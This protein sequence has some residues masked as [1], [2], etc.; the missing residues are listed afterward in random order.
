[1]KRD[2]VVIIEVANTAK[3]LILDKNVVRFKYT[4]EHVSWSDVCSLAEKETNRYES[5]GYHA[6][7]ADI[8]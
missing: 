7:V 4:F 5:K 8:R 3:N 6:V 2:W 1:M